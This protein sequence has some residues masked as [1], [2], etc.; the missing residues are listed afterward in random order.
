MCGINGYSF[1][2]NELIVRMNHVLRHRGPD[3]EGIFVDE[4]VT[5]G[6]RRLAI[7]D[8]TEKGKQPMSWKDYWITYNGEI[9]NFNELKNELT[10]AGHRF[11]SSTDTEVILHAYQEWGSDCV[12][13]FNGMWAFCIYDL[14]KELLFL[15]R[16]RFGIKPLYYFYDKQNIV[17]SSEIKGILQHPN[18]NDINLSAL[19]FYFYQKYIH[20]SHTIYNQI[21]TLKPSHNLI[22]DLKTRN[23]Q[24]QQYFSLEDE[25]AEQNKETLANRL[26]KIEHLLHD[27]IQ[28]RLIADVPVGSFLSGGLDSSMISAI[29][30]GKKSDFDTFSIGFSEKS[31]NEIPFSIRVANH[32]KTRHHYRY[33]NLDMQIT[34]QVLSHLDQPFGDASIIPTFLLSQITRE[35][36][37]VSLSGDA[38]D[39]LFG[40]Y[41]TYKAYKLAKFIPACVIRTGR[42]LFK[43]LPADDSYTSLRLKIS[44]FFK[45]YHPDRVIRHL[46][47]MSQTDEHERKNLLKENYMNVETLIDKPKGAKLIDIQLNDFVHYLAGDILPKVDTASMMAS[48]EA[49]IPFLDYRLVPLVLSLPEK[50]KIRNFK[51]KYLL[52]K[53][54]RK[55]LPSE[56]IN[57]KKQ[58]FSIPLSKWIKESEMIKKY[59]L[60]EKY[61]V[62]GL[63]DLA[64]VRKKYLV[65]IEKEA[66]CSRLLWLVFVFNYWYDK[67]EI[68]MSSQ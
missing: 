61:Y 3:G 6:H 43:T 49:R 67:Q 16:D 45:D 56:I 13:K 32:I 48:L 12:K 28:K 46:N 7:I 11:S 54:G 24:L 55:Y 5:L 53:I 36:V 19:N 39:E 25:I 64:Y 2:D 18:K 44:K 51:V 33:L 26:K 62:H 30:A 52:K 21:F 34:E 31:F 42:L 14:Q 41:D 57:R 40:G 29:I 60:E 8:L 38:G 66:D 65:H 22:F 63:I 23:I 17:F 9:Y 58:G 10:E 1:P 20:G 4:K 35:K 37:T 59:L 68:N 50:Y 47:W 27:S 15:S